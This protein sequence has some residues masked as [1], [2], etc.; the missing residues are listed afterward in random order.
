MKACTT[1]VQ[2]S[3]ALVA[4][5]LIKA[6]EIFNQLTKITAVEIDRYAFW[7]TT[8]NMYFLPSNVNTVFEVMFEV[9]MV[10]GENT[11]KSEEDIVCTR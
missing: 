6:W 3:K 10:P 7:K 1:K 9:D 11:S 4:Y 5:H 2:P 8:A